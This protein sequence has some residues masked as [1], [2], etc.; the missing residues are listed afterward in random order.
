M[1]KT[2]IKV[3]CGDICSPLMGWGNGITWGDSLSEFM[4][5]FGVYSSDGKARSS[6]VKGKAKVERW[7]RC[8]KL[9]W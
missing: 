1:R 7:Q 4:R 2:P 6:W 8:R 9:M 5:E 3:F